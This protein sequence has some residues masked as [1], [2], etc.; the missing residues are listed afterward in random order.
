MRA[1]DQAA[2]QTAALATMQ[3]IDPATIQVPFQIAVQITTVTARVVINPPV[4]HMA[5]TYLVVAAAMLLAELVD[6]EAPG[7]TLDSYKIGLKAIKP[8]N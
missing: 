7:P 1:I 3:V 4:T 8:S 5:V 2:V 6:Q